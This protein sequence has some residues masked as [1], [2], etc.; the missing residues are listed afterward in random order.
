[1]RIR[2]GFVSNS[3]SSSFIVIDA[4]KGYVETNLPKD[5]V[6]NA[7]LGCTEFGWGPETL[8]DIGSRIIFAYFQALY[9]DNDD[10]VDMLERC[11]KDNSDVQ[12]ITW[13]IDT[14]WC[15]KGKLDHGYIDHESASYGNMNTEMFDDKQ[16]L[17][18]F[19]FG[20]ASK[21]VLD[22]DNH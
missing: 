18:D 21:I 22:N 5:L 9:V 11:I 20:K 2:L 12:T 13:N 7:D 4:K 8:T 17:K 3:S 10:W 15:G 16:T 6:V 14:D 1:M 19:I